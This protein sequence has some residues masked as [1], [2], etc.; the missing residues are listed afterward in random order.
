MEKK[1]HA[2]DNDVESIYMTLYHLFLNGENTNKDLNIAAQYLKAAIKIENTAEKQALLREIY[3]QQNSFLPEQQRVRKA[4]M[5]VIA[6]K[7]DFAES[8]FAKYLKS[9]DQKEEALEHF[10]A[11][12]NF[13]EAYDLVDINDEEKIAQSIQAFKKGGA[14]T[15]FAKSL[16]LMKSN[17]SL[18]KDLFSFK[19][20][21]LT[22]WGLSWRYAVLGP[23]YAMF[24]TIH[25]NGALFFGV[26]LS[27]V[28][29]VAVVIGYFTNFGSLGALTSTMLFLFLW[30]MS[31]LISDVK[32][33][34]KFIA[35]CELCTQ[36]SPHPEIK[37]MDS[38]FG[39]SNK[40]KTT[41]KKSGF[42]ILP[43]ITHIFFALVIFIT[44]N[45]EYELREQQAQAERQ[46]QLEKEKL[47]Q[48]ERQAQLEKEKLAIDTLKAFHETITDK[49]YERAYNFFSDNLKRRIEYDNWISG[50]ETTVSSKASDIKIESKS[51]NMI[52]LSYILTAVDNP[53]GT[54]KFNS[55]ATLINT[56]DGWKLEAM[57]NKLRN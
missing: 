30:M 31:S 40:I 53:G 29:A 12:K 22:Y 46:A 19:E 33:R 24:R 3:E 18:L 39:N 15:E 55:T 27:T 49:K 21:P 16:N 6:D 32:R 44:V 2:Y 4:Y 25:K 50:F 51:E 41:S 34:Q 56:G 26:L 10:I 7:I 17:F 45:Q 35:A 48:E 11:G 13:K 23:I 1:N 14:D 43:I 57:S 5:Q 20:Q 38:V 9:H 37:K 8:E 42:L 47:A 54:R 36:I 52:T 28:I